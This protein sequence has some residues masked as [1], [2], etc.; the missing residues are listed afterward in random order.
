MA[1][2][3]PFTPGHARSANAAARLQALPCRALSVLQPC[4][5]ILRPRAGLF[6]GGSAHAL[7]T[8]PL[9]IWRARCCNVGAGRSRADTHC[10]RSASLP[11]S[12]CPSLCHRG[13][14]DSVRADLFAGRAERLRVQLSAHV[15]SRRRS[16]SFTFRVQYS[17]RSQLNPFVGDVSSS[18]G[19]SAS[20]SMQFTTT[21]HGPDV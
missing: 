21:R 1:A 11:F 9:V 12:I 20:E 15:L 2:T 5:A 6:A 18:L 3:L 14:K 8:R 4:A 19:D 16:R 17:A 7:S 13:V 10:D